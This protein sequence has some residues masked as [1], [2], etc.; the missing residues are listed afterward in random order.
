VRSLC[1]DEKENLFLGLFRLG[2]SLDYLPL[3]DLE[4]LLSQ[5]F[6]RPWT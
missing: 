2:Q 3:L 4:V 5:V 6:V 1:T